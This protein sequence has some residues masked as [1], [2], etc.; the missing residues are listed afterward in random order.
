MDKTPMRRERA[1]QIVIEES[2]QGE[3][4]DKLVRM[5]GL[6]FDNQMNYKKV[7]MIPPEKFPQICESYYL[8]KKDV[9][10]KHIGQDKKGSAEN[11]VN[12][13]STLSYDH[14]INY[15]CDFDADAE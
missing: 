14:F 9:K 2:K 13:N 11:G 4:E 12:P 6:D 15:Y 1:K 3:V 8:M 5:K 10:I 7:K